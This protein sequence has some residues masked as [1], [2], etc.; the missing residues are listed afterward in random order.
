VKVQPPEGKQC[1]FIIT[2]EIK[3]GWGNKMKVEAHF[4]ITAQEL[5][6]LTE[7]PSHART[8]VDHL[9]KS[10]MAWMQRVTAQ[11]RQVGFKCC[12]RKGACSCERPCQNIALNASCMLMM[13]PIR[14]LP[15]NEFL[16]LIVQNGSDCGNKSC[17]QRSW[18]TILHR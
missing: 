7:S 4:A 11:A 3:D 9:T 14:G 5:V 6:Q 18:D 1:L 16:A 12:R 8:F 2:G 13:P 15:Q 17:F 10:N